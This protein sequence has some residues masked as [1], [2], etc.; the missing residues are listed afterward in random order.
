[1]TYLLLGLSL[2]LSAGISPGPLL[3]L[4]LTRT[5]ARGFGAGLRVALSPL[6]TDAPIILTTLLIFSALP[7][8]FETAVTLLGGLYV[9]YL[10]VDTIRGAG[11]A[12]LET[13]S[14]T[15]ETASID[16]WQGALVN[17]LSPHPWL[18][19]IAIGSPT[20][21]RAWQDGPLYALAF[22]AGFYTLLVGGKIAVAAA[23]AGGRRF[24]TGAWYGR[25]LWAAGLLLCLFG[26]LLLWQAMQPIFAGTVTP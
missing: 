19:W 10:G 11:S 15:A 16:L 23:A 26:A 21:A 8:F 4:V 9:V 12:N 17:I 25:L 2:G 3:T 1:M 18:F 24:L 22:L 7:P 6:I 13:G 5:L 20:L 14:V